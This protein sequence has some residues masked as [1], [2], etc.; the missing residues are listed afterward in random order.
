VD[1]QQ[2][3]IFKTSEET[4]HKPK[5]GGMVGDMLYGVEGCEI[6][7]QKLV[8]K[9]VSHLFEFSPKAVFICLFDKCRSLAK[10]STQETLPIPQRVNVVQRDYDQWQL[11]EVENSRVL[12]LHAALEKQKAEGLGS[13]TQRLIQVTQNRPGKVL[14]YS[15]VEH[16]LNTTMNQQHCK[17]VWPTPVVRELDWYSKC[18]PLDTGISEPTSQLNE[19]Q[20]SMIKVVLLGQTG[21]GKSTIGNC[22]LGLKSNTGF[23]TSRDTDSCTDDTMGIMGKWFSNG[24][25]CTVI[26]TPGMDDSDGRDTEHIENIIE[27][28]KKENFINSFVLVRNGQNKRISKSFKS[29]LTIFELM[30]GTEF[31]S[32]VVIDVSH[33]RYED[34]DSMK[35]EIRKWNNT[36]KK[37]FRKAK[38]A[39]LKTVF[40]DASNSKH[41]S[42][43][44]NAEKL[45]G[46]CQEMEEFECKDF[47]TTKTEMDLLKSD[48][49]QMKVDHENFKASAESKMKELVRE[50]EKEKRVFQEKQEKVEKEMKH[51]K[52]DFIS[53]IDTER[54]KVAKVEEEKE[55]FERQL[56]KTQN[57]H[58]QNLKTLEDASTKLNDE[59]RELET[60]MMK[61]REQM[62]KHHNEKLKKESN[63]EMEDQEKEMVRNT[64]KVKEAGWKFAIVISN[65]NYTD[66]SGYKRLPSVKEA[67]KNIVQCLKDEH[68]YH[69]NVM[70]NFRQGWDNFVEDATE[71]EYVNTEDVLDTL[72][73]YIENLQEAM[74]KKN[75]KQLDSLMFYYLGHGVCSGGQDIL[76]GT[77]G[78]LTSVSSIQKTL[79]E[80][81]FAKKYYIVLDSCR[82]LR[83]G[84]N[85]AEDEFVQS[86]DTNMTVV[87]GNIDI[88]RGGV[89]PDVNEIT[90]TTSLVKLLEG[91]RKIKV[92]NLQEN[93]NGIWD[94][95]QVIRNGRVMYTA[96]VN[97][98]PRHEN[99]EFP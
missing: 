46:Y 86:E 55:A 70:G 30:F 2:D 98:T 52:E 51:Q 36:I 20:R 91:G 74:K 54:I 50:A 85:V 59:K 73:E 33:V 97:T 88:L 18:W 11:G 9:L 8:F 89:A 48:K 92:K 12:I 6:S 81:I 4:R 24:A 64:E 76:V 3:P 56:Q 16:E 17:V 93:L 32:H 39:S 99:E 65:D 94:K 37:K 90:M 62:E 29:M 69:F 1:L 58:K 28:L 19:S 23:E 25:P 15:D 35:Q 41:A 5:H 43:Q 78:N 21:S 14:L 75:K 47:E 26:D 61:E 60:R 96:T 83:N 27:Y 95:A 7:E 67:F 68:G 40:L 44:E 10:D 82:K 80:R 84:L 22:L 71:N 87:Q 31:W 57:E 77:T 34:T 38:D 13:F 42:F 72:S 49:N 63:E 79:Q 45:W 66:D 53:K